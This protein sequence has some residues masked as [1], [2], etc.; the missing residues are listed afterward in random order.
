MG[1]HSAKLGGKIEASD[2]QLLEQHKA[3]AV[4][5]ML[6][7]ISGVGPVTAITMALAVNPANFKAG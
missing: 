3:N 2:R 5:W 7:E 1:R 6:V 4:S